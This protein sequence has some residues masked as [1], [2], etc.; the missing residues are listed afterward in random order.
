MPHRLTIPGRLCALALLAAPASAA[1]PL[2]GHSTHGEA[3]NEGPRQEAQL[4]AGT[5]DVDFPVTT[6]KPAA[7]RFFNQGIGQLHGFWYYE[8][9]RSFRQAARIDPDCAMAYWGMAMA[10][11]NNDNRAR[12]FLAKTTALKDKL[13]EKEKLWIGALET[14]L[15]QEDSDKR[16]KKQRASDIIRDFDAIVQS[17]PADIE[18]RAFLAWKLWHA[19]DQVPIPSPS[20]VNAIL[21]TV[22]AASPYHPAHHYRIHLWDGIKPANALRSAALCGPAAPAIAHMWHMPG[23]IY[24]KLRRFDD[25]AWQQEASTRVDHA[26]M[27]DQFL[28]PDQIHN[29]AHNEEWLIR[30][31][32]EQGRAADAIGLARNLIAHPRHPDINTLD[33]AR[34][35][36]S[37]GRTRL[38]ETLLKWDLWEEI[39]ALPGSP[40]FEDAPQISHQITLHRALGIAAFFRLDQP[41]LQAA[42]SSL[43]DLQKR[44]KKEAEKAAADTKPAAGA[45]SGKEDGKAPAKGEKTGEK[46][47]EKKPSPATQAAQDLKALLAAVRNQEDAPDLLA[48]T[49]TLD[50]TIAARALL[51]FGKETEA[52][53]M[54]SKFPQDLAGHVHKAAILLACGRKDD[55]R[56]AFDAA[57]SAAYAMDETLPAADQLKELASTFG[58]KTWHGP[59]PRRN[60]IGER[61][62]LDILGPIHWHPPAAPAWEALNLDT[63]PVQNGVKPGT[64]QLVMFYLGSQCT[65]CVEQLNIFAAKAAAFEAAGIQLQAVSPEPPSI[66]GRVHEH[67]ASDGRYPFP[68]LCDPSLAA[69]K[70]FRAHDDFEEEALHAT[71]L[72]DPAGRIRWID[73]GYQ[74]FT[75]ADFLLNEAT[76]LL[77]LP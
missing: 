1:D 70:S 21:D 13:T 35:S 18:A 5:G 19:K 62:P 33:K 74:P 59:K 8:A 31:W 36:A 28:L 22:F 46:P 66:A 27:I 47:A 7:Q 15:R 30:T 26:H 65:H 54:A 57:H 69:F 2:P 9:E 48:K 52:T 49:P 63:V 41:A 77:G 45:E 6:A 39:A 67:A 73:I 17:D 55:A 10:N 76:R 44:E 71:I 72:I 64:A 3:F 50:K 32:N 4:I 37:Y 34:S 58:V 38:I 56:K 75:K 29:Y 23:H 53:D 40:W 60:D 16:D 42:I 20:A 11:V 68:I 43:E 14:Y 25:A 12:G 24:S 51:A 61:P